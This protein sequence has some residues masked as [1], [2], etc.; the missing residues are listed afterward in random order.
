MVGLFF[1]KQSVLAKLWK[2][3]LPTLVKPTRCSK[4]L[5]NNPVV[6]TRMFL[7]LLLFP[8]LGSYAYLYGRHLLEALLGTHMSTTSESNRGSLLER[9]SKGA[10]GKSN[11]AL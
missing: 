4:P 10:N 11:N 7:Y 9:K 2:T 6:S 1:G 3:Q 5:Q 8:K